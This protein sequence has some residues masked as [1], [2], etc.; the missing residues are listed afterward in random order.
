[1]PDRR[2]ESPGS[3]DR[4]NIKAVMYRGG[5]GEKGG[6]GNL[7][8]HIENIR[9]FGIEPVEFI[10]DS[11][12][13]MNDIIKFCENL[14][15]RAVVSS[16]F[17]DGG[18][19]AVKLAEAVL[20]SISVNKDKKLKFQYSLEM[21]LKERIETLA[22]NIYGADGVDFDRRAETDIDLLTDNGYGNLPVCIAK[23]PK[24][25]SDN[26]GLKGRPQ[27]FRITVN[28]VRISA[29]AGF[30]VMICGNINTM[31]GLPKMPAAL[32]IKVMPDGRVT[33]LT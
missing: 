18:K 6:T 30:V 8:K 3:S 10:D 21:S 24:S 15:V 13:D 28:E 2:T 25:L 29:G 31:P 17:E 33:G 32:R 22:L 1:M 9:K 14:G 19:G 27:K 20:D 11:E 4:C 7:S 5:I 16:H 23:T 12:K 26:P